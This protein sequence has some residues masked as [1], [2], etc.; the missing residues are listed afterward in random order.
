MG[1]NLSNRQIAQELDLSVSDVQVMTERLRSGLVAKIPPVTLDGE[2]E[3]DE[4]YVVA[5]HKGNPAAVAKKAGSD[6]AAGSKAPPAGAHWRKK[7]H[8]SSA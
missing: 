3:V 7:N 5:G 1:L 4:L 2:V 6:G 8:Q